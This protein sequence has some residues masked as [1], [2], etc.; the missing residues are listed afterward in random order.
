ML[1]D[2]QRFYHIMYLAFFR[3]GLIPRYFKLY[4]WNYRAQVFINKFR[5]CEC[6]PLLGSTLIKGFKSDRLHIL[7][8][9]SEI[10]CRVLHFLSPSVRIR[11]VSNHLRLNLVLVLFICVNLFFILD[12]TSAFQK[13]F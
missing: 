8:H 13:Y 6:R 11:K 10:T 3:A 4:K 5:L 1:K 2:V 9:Y 7:T 12:Y